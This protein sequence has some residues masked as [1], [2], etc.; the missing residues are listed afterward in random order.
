M[1]LRTCS[2]TL[3]SNDYIKRLLL[4]SLKRALSMSE[5]YRLKDK[6]PL[7]CTLPY[8]PVWDLLDFKKIFSGEHASVLPAN[9]QGL[10]VMQ[11]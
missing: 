4:D 6:I 1:V 7:L 9:A 8:N 5:Q 2:G 3:D 10:H 11:C